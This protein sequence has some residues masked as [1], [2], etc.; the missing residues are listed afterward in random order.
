MGWRKLRSQEKPHLTLDT[1]KLAVTFTAQMARKITILRRIIRHISLLCLRAWPRN[2][3][4]CGVCILCWQA[5]QIL[6]SARLVVLYVCGR[7]TQIWWSHNVSHLPCSFLHHY[8]SAGVIVTEDCETAPGTQSSS[9]NR[10]T[11]T[12]AHLLKLQP[13]WWTGR[14]RLIIWER[15]FKKRHQFRQELGLECAGQR[16]K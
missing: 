7:S 15:I 10:K 5:A 11:N 6:Y 9:K 1:E 2:Y 3:F 16:D 4:S 8:S 14:K 13:L 12:S